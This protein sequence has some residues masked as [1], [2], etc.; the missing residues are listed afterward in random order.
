MSGSFFAK[1]LRDEGR[2][3]KMNKNEFTEQ[4]WDGYA[5]V[6]D[7]LTTLTPYRD[8]LFAAA[9]AIPFTTSSIHILDAACGTGNVSAAVLEYCTQ[10]SHTVTLTGVDRSRAMLG[11]AT[12]KAIPG[13]TFM[14]GDLDA[15]LPFPDHTFEVIIC[16]NGLYAVRDPEWTLREFARMLSP[17]GTIVIVTPKRGYEN[18]LVLR[19]HAGSMKPERYWMDAHATPEREKA[20]IHE[21]TPDDPELRAAM[22]MIAKHNRVIAETAHFHFFDQ[23]E[24]RALVDRAGMTIRSYAL[25]YADQCHFAV[26]SQCDTPNEHVQT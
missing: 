4:N 12:M 24:F 2:E 7:T 22:E 11:I 14:L 18:G 3:R 21:A 23:R 19:A 9:R 25:A 20:L 6:Y 16:V 8:L 10:S 15:P 17:R 26:L 13:A 5:R 1:P